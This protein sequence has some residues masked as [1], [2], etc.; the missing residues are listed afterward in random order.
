MKFL[1]KPILNERKKDKEKYWNAEK[2]NDFD[3]K[4]NFP[5][6]V[7]FSGIALSK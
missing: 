6:Q 7:F 3:S 1:N 2:S 5:S 4:Q